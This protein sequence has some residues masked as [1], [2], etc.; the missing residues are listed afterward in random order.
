MSFTFILI[1]TM[2]HGTLVKIEKS[3][4]LGEYNSYFNWHL[5]AKVM[6]Q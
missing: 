3:I 1:V 5:G 2:T 4:S 6:A